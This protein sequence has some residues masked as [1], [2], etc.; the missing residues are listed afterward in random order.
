[1]Q[2]IILMW[3]RYGA[4]YRIRFRY[5]ALAPLF[6][7]I[8]QRFASDAVSLNYETILIKFRK[9]ITFIPSLTSALYTQS[10][11]PFLETHYMQHKYL[12]A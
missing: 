11:S 12:K 10:A 5:V 4:P 6:R 8:G 3:R 2:I 9:V 1:M 7:A